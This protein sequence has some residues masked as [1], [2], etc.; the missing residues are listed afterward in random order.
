MLFW[1]TCH[2]LTIETF[3]EFFIMNAKNNQKK[4]HKRSGGRICTNS[5]A[6]PFC[7]VLT[8]FPLFFFRHPKESFSI[9]ACVGKILV[10][11][12]SKPIAY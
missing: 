9:D 5:L 4:S 10:E 2:A 1:D 3:I 8:K 11:I 6:V 7:S 12:I